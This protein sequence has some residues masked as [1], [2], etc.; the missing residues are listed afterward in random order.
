MDNIKDIELDM[1]KEL[2]IISYKYDIPFYLGYG[3]ALGA[4]RE[5]GFIPWDSDIDV[6]VEY[7]N[8]EQLCKKLFEELDEKYTLKSYIYD[9]DYDSLK[10][11]ISLKNHDHHM[12][13]IDLFP[14]VGI[15]SDE[16]LQNKQV[17]LAHFIYRMYYAKKLKSFELYRNQKFKL[18][19]SLIIK[20]PLLLVPSK[21]IIKKFEKVCNEY[22]TH[23]VQYLHNSCGSYGMKEIIP[24]GYLGKGKEVRFENLKVLI[25][26]LYEEYLS[27]IYGKDYMIPKKNNY[28]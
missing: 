10:A 9:K 18:I 13:H 12:I 4:V 22:S 1:L 8:Y 24:K 11:R 20:I 28:L 16:K 7:H 26:E 19:A 3:S 14:L 25:P 2:Q 23:E 5:K 21:V 17:R 27:H 15:S 6:I